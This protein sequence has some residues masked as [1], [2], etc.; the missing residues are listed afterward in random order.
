MDSPLDAPLPALRD[1]LKLSESATSKNGEP[2]WVIQDTV[3]NRFYQ[4][5]WL[6]FECLLRWGSTAR[7]ISS[8]IASETP[9]NPEPEQV[10]EFR[11]FLEGHQLL[12]P[13]TAAV[14]R[15]QQRS[16]GNAWLSW[17]WWLHHYLFF[18]IP[19]LHPQSRLAFLAKKLDWL[20]SSTAAWCIAGLSL[21]GIVLVMH[22]WDT[23]THD[24]VNSFSMEGAIGFALA[25]IVGKTLHELGHALVATRLGLNVAHMGIAFVV[26]W[27]MLYTDTGE[28]W[29]LR[30]PR[31]RLAISSAGIITELTLAGLATLGWALCEPGALRNA[32]LYLAT[33]NWL[34][35]LALN[36]SPFMRFDGY[37]IACDLLDFPNLHERSSAQ[38]RIFLRRKLL[39][40]KEDWPEPF[41]PSRRRMLIA[42]AFG[43][44]IYRLALFLGIAIAV[45]LLFFKV[46]G[47]ALFIVEL[48]WFIFMP[49]WREMSYWWKNRQNIRSD[50]RRWILAVIAGIF[51]LFALPWSWQIHAPGVARAEQQLTV[52]SPYPARLTHVRDKG[53]VMAGEV[54]VTLDQPDISSKLEQSQSS[55]RSYQDRL[56]GLQAVLDGQAEQMATR[57]RVMVEYEQIQSARSEIARLNLQAPFNGLWRDIDKDWKPG[58]WLGTKEAVGVLIDPSSWQVDAYVAQ[59]QVAKLSPGNAVRFYAKGQFKPIEGKV[60]SIS[61]TKANYLSHPVL[62]SRFGGPLETTDHEQKLA[63]KSSVFHVLIALDAPPP[64]LKETLGDVQIKGDKRSLLA[65]ALRHLLSILVRESGF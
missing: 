55:M 8:Q 37:F 22:Q 63:P 38:A 42:F 57:Q 47:I 30:N 39:G 1:D 49:V 29:K 17:N 11:Q 7:Q 64:G 13:T 60:V 43:T 59:D 25:L 50:R 41:S 23:F 48:A 32:L 65:D 36:A 40:F 2:S 51:C 3:I 46:L 45:Y 20:F 52:F 31:Q 19:L 61:T 15:L 27:P 5:G 28:S 54:L 12:R 4:I 26:L 33:T 10:L 44:W 35:S 6:E 34:L 58:Q 53:S 18:R 16:E 56:T 24:V 62:A 14:N 21:L 9:L